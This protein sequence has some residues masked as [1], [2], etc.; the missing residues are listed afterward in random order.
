MYQDIIIVKKSWLNFAV[1]APDEPYNKGFC[2][3]GC[4]MPNTMVSA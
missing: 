3:P 4:T 1:E 2:G